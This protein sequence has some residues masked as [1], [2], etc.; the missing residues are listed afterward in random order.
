MYAVRIL[1]KAHAQRK[2]TYI[3]YYSN[4]DCW[5]FPTI[6]GNFKKRKEK[7]II[8]VNSLKAKQKNDETWHNGLF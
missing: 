7:K 8:K 3:G 4:E 5:R 1:Y 6:V 2:Y